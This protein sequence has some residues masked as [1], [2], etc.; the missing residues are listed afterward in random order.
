MIIDRNREATGILRFVEFFLTR[1]IG[2]LADCGV[3]WLLADMVFKGSYVGENII[4][5]TISFEVATFVNYVTSY[6]WIWS[7]RI[8][9]RSAAA[10]FRRFLSFNLSSVVGF[11]IKMAF[12]L[13]LEHWTGWHVVLCNLVALC[14]SGFFNYF[15]AEMW[16]FGKKSEHP[17]RKVLSREELAEFTPL[18]AGV[19]GQ[20][21]ASLVMKLLGIN[22]LNRLYDSVADYEGVP[23]ATELLEKMGCHCLIG[24]AER[25]DTLPE[26]AFVTISNHP[27]GG[28]DGIMLVDVFGRC[29]PDYKVMVN[30]LLSRVKS[31]AST[32]ITVTPRTDLSDGMSGKSLSGVRN[33][34]LRLGEGHPMGFF[35]AGAVSD[36]HPRQRAIA[37]REWQESLIRLIL[38]ARVPI[39]P[40]RFLD[41]NSRL[42]YLLGLVDWKVRILRLP[43]ELLNKRGDHHRM[44]I[45]ETITVDEQA[46]FTDVAAFSDFLRKKVYEMPV[47]E[48]F[49]HHSTDVGK[50]SVGSAFGGEVSNDE[51]LSVG[52]TE[53]LQPDCTNN[54]VPLPQ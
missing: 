39:V 41:R 12:L 6:I 48:H 13:L 29:R 15:L 27:Y 18:F 16:V 17:G 8:D 24:H 20:R 49:V 9:D 42:F 14:V 35:P 19:W 26:G 53:C 4:S 3:L 25:L 47:P 43:H 46:A 7:T 33:V 52:T 11:V 10:F 21:F 22:K 44:V 23:F 34:L 51:P 38:K 31:L 28:L 37:D 36:Y 45:G 40:V 2:T 50:S 54:D 30:D 32:F 1:N 5:P